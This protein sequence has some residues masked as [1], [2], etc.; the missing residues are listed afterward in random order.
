M[1]CSVFTGLGWLMHQ[2]QWI[3]ILKRNGLWRMIKLFSCYR[4]IFQGL[5][6]F[7]F[8]MDQCVLNMGK[9]NYRV[10]K[11]LNENSQGHNTLIHMRSVMV[12]LQP[13]WRCITIRYTK[14]LFPV[15][16]TSTYD[17]LGY[18]LLLTIHTYTYCDLI[19]LDM[20]LL[21][22]RQV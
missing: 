1:V 15:I 17:T 11:I 7:I 22:L 5:L 2:R 8:N 10:V 9:Q 6:I 18:L 12:Y 14:Y 3:W 19:F 20:V 16:K 13:A 21:K 4:M